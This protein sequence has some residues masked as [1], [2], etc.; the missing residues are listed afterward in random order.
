MTCK[1]LQEEV[2]AVEKMLASIV[3]DILE[4]CGCTLASDD[5]S[6]VDN[7]PLLNIMLVTPKGACFRQSIDTRRQVKVGPSFCLLNCHCSC[8]GPK[9]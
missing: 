4:T 6:A 7:R 8:D 1:L 2:E 3:L 9:S 5:W